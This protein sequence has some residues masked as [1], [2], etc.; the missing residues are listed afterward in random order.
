[1]K[2]IVTIYDVSQMA[3]LVGE[4]YTHLHWWNW[5]KKKLFEEIILWCYKTITRHKR[6]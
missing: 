4:R 3:S 1:M 6:S 5:R 2:K